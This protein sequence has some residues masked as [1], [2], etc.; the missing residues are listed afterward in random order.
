MEAPH[1]SIH[2]VSLKI[3][4]S[5]TNTCQICQS[6]MWVKVDSETDLQTI[7]LTITVTVLSIP[8]VESFS[9][10]WNLSMTFWTL[11]YKH[12]ET[13][14]CREPLIQSQ[15]AKLKASKYSYEISF[16]EKWI[17][18]EIGLQVSCQISGQS[19]THSSVQ[20]LMLIQP[21]FTEN[22]PGVRASNTA[23]NNF[24]RFTKRLHWMITNEE[25]NACLFQLQNKLF[26]M[27]LCRE[28]PETF[29]GRKYFGSCLHKKPNWFLDAF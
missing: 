28:V 12:T 7:I 26:H 5:A 6:E 3:K 20:N 10:K 4:I 24:Q 29:S 2:V 27:R 15:S 11:F 17:H 1:I 25:T 23:E 22:T 8:R 14:T 19:N 18:S 16:P 9:Y 21:K 13:Q